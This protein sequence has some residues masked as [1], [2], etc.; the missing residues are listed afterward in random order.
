MVAD[1]STSRRVYLDEASDSPLLDEAREEMSRWVQVVGDPARPYAEGLHARRALERARGE[2]ADLVGVAPRNVTFCSSATEG[3]NWLVYAAALSGAALVVSKVEH[4][5]VAAT[6]RKLTAELDLVLVEA[7]V[8]TYGR[9]TPDSLEAAIVEA[10]SRAYRG[11]PSHAS[12]FCFI[13]HANH[14]LGTVQPLAELAETARRFGARIV[15]DAAQTAGRIPVDLKELGAVALVISAHKFGGPKGAAAVATA[16]GFRPRPLLYG[17][18]Q[19]RGRR[20]GTEDVAAVSAFGAAC[21]R[22]LEDL[23]SEAERERRLTE[24]LASS[25]QRALPGTRV[26]GHPEWRVPHILS[27]ELAGVQGEA[28]VL[29]LDK[30]GFSVHSG[31]ACAAEAFEPSPILAAVGAD[32]RRNLRLSVG[33]STSEEDVERFLAALTQEVARLQA[34]ASRLGDAP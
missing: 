29:S 24:T 13:Q 6:A 8:D 30:K 25:L 33:R 20:A 2:V 28:V 18:S 19:E 22:V 10:A 17:A 5:A 31:S 14:E 3:L 12:I 15:C 9:V 27:L 23:E 21:K 34:L 4:S 16:P 32:S 11:K 26:L 7:G 1:F